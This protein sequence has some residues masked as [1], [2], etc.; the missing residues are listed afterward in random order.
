MGIESGDENTRL[1]NPVLA[2]QI[3]D[4]DAQ[5]LLQR[6]TSDRGRN[7]LQ[8]KMRRRQRDTQI[9]PG[10]HHDHLWRLRFLGQIFSVPGEV[11]SGVV[12]HPFVY[13]SRHHCRKLAGLTP[14]ERPI[15]QIQHVGR[16][17]RI[18][19]PRDCTDFERERQDIQRPGQRRIRRIPVAQAN[20]RIQSSGPLGKHREVAEHDNARSRL[21]GIALS[22]AIG[23]P[24]AKFRTDPRRLAGRHGDD[25]HGAR[26]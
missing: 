10:E 26:H 20:A 7:V 14:R 4:Q 6:D 22:G 25:G 15:Q 8:W 13:G 23:Q 16:V 24:Q 9:A 21:R 19:L 12:D 3:G 1:G 18:K 2:M 11:H 5:R 17:G